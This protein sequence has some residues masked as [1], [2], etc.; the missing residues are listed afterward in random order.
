ITNGRKIRQWHSNVKRL[1][2]I[3]HPTR[4]TKE[5][6]D[7]MDA[8]IQAAKAAASEAESKTAATEKPVTK[9]TAKVNTAPSPASAAVTLDAT[10]P[11]WALPENTKNTAKNDTPTVLAIGLGY[12]RNEIAGIKR[13]VFD[14]RYIHAR[15]S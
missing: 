1:L 9:S 2:E 11:T 6:L 14:E 4:V 15:V 13:E 12:G 5:L 10:T 7:E 8:K 3:D